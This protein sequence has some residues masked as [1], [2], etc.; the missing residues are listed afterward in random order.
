MYIYC[1]VDSELGAGIKAKNNSYMVP[2]L[3][4]VIGKTDSK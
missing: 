4:E 3:V 1:V 2:P